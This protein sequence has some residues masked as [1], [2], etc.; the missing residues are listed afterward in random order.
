TQGTLPNGIGVILAGEALQLEEANR[1]LLI[2]YG[3]A[4]VI[5]LLVLIAQFESISSPVIVVL[6]VP[7][8]LAAAVYALTFTGISLNLYSQIGLVLLIGLMAKNGILLVE[9]ADQLRSEGH[10]VRDAVYDAAMIRLRPI[11][12]T[13]ISTVL[14]ALPL[15]L[16]TGAG[17]EARQSIGWVVFGGLG[18]SALFTLFL[19]PVLYLA[20]ARL[21]SPRAAE[22]A[23]LEEELAAAEG[24]AQAR[25][26]PAE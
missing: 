25:R 3:F 1:D 21:A 14:G 6:T 24:E 8:A 16:S 12:M 10:S 22:A 26:E 20:I 19:T 4:F 5:V 17:A 7:F 23:A 13:V 18:L 9:F 15:I 2:T 11:S